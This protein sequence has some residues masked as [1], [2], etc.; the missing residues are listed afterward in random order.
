MTKPTTLDYVTNTILRPL[1]GYYLVEQ[2][3]LNEVD[4]R[5][6]SL[7]GVE[8]GCLVFTRHT[9]HWIHLEFA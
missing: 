6:A 3:V 4:A 7:S 5:L 8:D 9:Y 2:L 1:I